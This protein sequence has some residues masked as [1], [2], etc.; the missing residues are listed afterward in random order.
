MAERFH[1]TLEYIEALPLSRLHEW[2][3]IRDGREKGQAE[4]NRRESFL[5]GKGLK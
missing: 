4:R 2:Q 1:W 5:I 3:Q